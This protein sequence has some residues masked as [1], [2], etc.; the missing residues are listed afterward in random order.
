MRTFIATFKAN[1]LAAGVADDDDIVW[2]VLRRFAIL[3]FDFGVNG[4]LARLH[5]QALARQVLADEDVS[6][7]ESLWSDLI[8]ISIGI[9][10]VGG[11]D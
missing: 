8:E 6:R 7:A 11:A 1:L 5:A 10:K 4:A 2:K 9:G 3:V